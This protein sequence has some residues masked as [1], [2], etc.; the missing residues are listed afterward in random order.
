M[1]LHDRPKD[2]VMIP[3]THP[4]LDRGQAIGKFVQCQSGDLVLWDSRLVHCN[5]P[6]FAIEER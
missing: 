5:S 1:I 3:S 4:I 6:A 2:F